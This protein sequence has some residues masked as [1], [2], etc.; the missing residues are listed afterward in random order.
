MGSPTNGVI[1]VMI[2]PFTDA[3]QVDREGLERLVEWYIDHGASALFAVC[4]SSEMFFLDRDERREVAR[5]VVDATRGRIPVVVS[6]HVSDDHAGQAADLRAV[7]DIGADALIL[8]TNR[9]ETPGTPG[10]LIE[11]AERLMGEVPADLPLG[12]YECPRPARRL[13]TDEELRHFAQT[14]RFVLLKDVSCDLPTIRRRL[15]I[16]AGTP[17]AI[18]N[19]NAAIAFDAM[20]AGARGFCG[21]FANFA[22]DLYRWLLDHGEAQPDIA[23]EIAPMLALGSMCEAFGYPT[24]AKLYH[25]RIGTFASTHTRS[26][27]GD[28]R[29]QVWA[30]DPLLDNI[31]AAIGNAR[32][33]IAAT[34]TA[35]RAAA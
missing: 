29:E 13:L 8:I 21:I 2:T 28:V 32:A 25:Q 30:I 14:G 11:R 12:F 6:G 27:P 34:K 5:I 23:A 1:P 3:G 35:S 20:K 26:L 15:D 7:A 4:L 22:P 18:S 19:A 24:I 17:L 10:T 33:R 9:L 16:V 31:V